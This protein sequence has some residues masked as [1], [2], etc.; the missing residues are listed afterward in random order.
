V[1]PNLKLELWRAGLRQNKLAKLLELDETVLS[2]IVNGYREPST[3]VRHKI[4]ALLHK[5][6]SWLFVETSIDEPP[7]VWK[8]T[9]EPEHS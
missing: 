5:D 2:K 7:G 9:S 4:A 8:Q 6:E 3:E 1:Y